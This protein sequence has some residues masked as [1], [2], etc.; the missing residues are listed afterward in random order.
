MDTA[1]GPR[2]NPGVTQLGTISAIWRY[3]VKAMMGEQLN[4]TTVAADGVAGDRA[5][6][7]IDGDGKIGTGKIRRKWG[8]LFQSRARYITEPGANGLPP[9]EITLPDGERMMTDDP[10]IETRLSALVGFDARLITEAPSPLV[11][12]SPPL[13]QV[14]ESD[15]EPLLQLPVPN[16]FFD[17][18][19]LHLLTSSTLA[20]LRDLSPGTTFD[21]R[22]FRPNFIV[23]SPE[24]VTG[25]EE[26]GW[27]GKT[28][29]IGPD[30]R[31]RVTMPTI[32]CVV[33]TNP[34]DDLPYDPA[35][36]KTAAANN[37][38]FVGVYASVEQGGAVH[39]GDEVRFA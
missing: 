36:L 10:D 19:S 3:P 18:G 4:A 26:N 15:A 28:I 27:S 23:Q 8:A 37:N 12:E 9:A 6:A 7:L 34:Q 14:P 33:T 31:I 22:R 25:F 24:G 39:R 1:D 17:L 29:A 35:V 20:T 32:R 38:A 2:Y 11:L 21:P 5:Y 16:R 13:G 30:V